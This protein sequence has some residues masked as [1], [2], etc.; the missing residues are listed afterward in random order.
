MKKHLI[1]LAAAFFLACDISAQ[2]SARMLRDPDVSDSQI[3]FVYAGDIWLVSKNGG[4]AYKLSSPSGE[5]KFPKFSPD[6][7][8]IAFTANYNGNWDVY[9]IPNT[10]GLPKR[11]TSH[12]DADMVIDWNPAGDKVL[13]SSSR[14][15]GRQRFS[16]L[17]EVGMDGGLPTKLAP[18]YGSLASYSPDGSKLAFNFKSRINRTWKRY[19]G[20]WAPD[21]WTYDLATNTSENITNNPSSD[22][23]PMWSG[24]KIYYLS[25]DGPNSRYNIWSYD[26]GA[27]AKTQITN[28]TEYD[29]HYP[30]LGPSEIVYENEGKLYLMNLSNQESREVEVNVITDQTSLAVKRVDASENLGWF[31]ISPDGKR[32]I[33]SARGDVFTVPAED[34]ITRNLTRTSGAYDRTPSW[35]PDGKKIAYWTDE[36]GEY[37]LKI[38]NT[39]NGTSQI[40]SNYS[41]GFRYAMFWSP[42]SKKIAFVDQTMAFQYF[43]LNTKQ[44][45]KIGEGRYLFHGGLNNY[46]FSWS[47]DSKWIAFTQENANRNTSIYLFNTATKT[48]QKMTSGYYNDFSPTFDPDNKYL[49]FLTNRNISP[50]YSSLD[51]TFIY[52]N[53]TMI[54]A[55]PLTKSTDSPLKP[56]NDE[57]EV[58]E[59]KASDDENKKDKKK[60]GDADESVK[61]DLAGF[62]ERIVLLP[63]GPGNY[64]ALEAVSGKVVFMQFPYTGSPENSSDV[65]YYDIEEREVKTII[66]SING[67]IEVSADGKKVAVANRGQHA[68]LDIAEGQKMDKT[69]DLSNMQ[70]EVDPMA[71]WQQIFADSWRFQRDYF[72]DKDMHG[73]D[74]NAI[75]KQYGKLISQCVTRWDVNYVLGEMIGELNASHTYRGGGDL[76]N[77]PNVNV[78]YL[79]V[80]WAKENGAYRIKRI[81]RGAPWDAEVVSPLDAPGVNINVGDYILAVNGV[82]VDITKDPNMAFQGMAG[83]TV[84]LTLNNTPSLS[85]SR[86]QLVETLNSESRLRHLEWIENNRKLVDEKTN[87]RVG[88]VYVRSTGID[89]QNELIRQFTAQYH[90][91]GLIID[92]R[93]NSGGQIPDRFIEMLDRKP[94]AFWAVRDGD[95][96]QWPPVAN[97]GPKAMLINGWSGSGGDAFP[98]YFRK[99]GLGP[100]IGTRTWGGL[101]GISGAPSLI[102]GGVVTVPT[103]RMYNPDGTWFKEGY[104]VDPDIE[105]KEN[106]GELARGTDAQLLRAIEW[107]NK[108]L[109]NY[110]GIP[111]RPVKEKR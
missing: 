25:D 97:F 9:V 105:V 16:Q 98:D 67:G 37:Q 68:I 87:G 1:L 93:F 52:P 58:S 39:E 48:S 6:G 24:N 95:T 60:D 44:T 89:G 85:G 103:F 20:G 83:E 110:Q 2:I 86:T 49:F 51:N 15:S 42:D 63:V 111:S 41:S 12:G 3:A 59:E 54:A 75:K 31:D 92:E 13:F 14:E 8:K 5:E 109:E 81:V 106:P 62:E 21:I 82:P 80:D 29:I 101:I 34:G 45:I 102:D 47:S 57:V 28:Y 77:T 26:I 100:L 55:V 30:S 27:G 88:Y 76:E 99:A 64:G 10:G 17:F 50:A 40:V 65:K 74:W 61:I 73:L 36:T 84:E 66:G 79:G 94:L 69:I 107:I 32:L 53:S 78:G 33:I 71:E 18:P 4:T 46:T 90:K 104:G 56:K 11:L 35:S 38:H 43:D 70:M 22:E 7:S 72:Y 23:F 108:E 91:D 96:W 19:K